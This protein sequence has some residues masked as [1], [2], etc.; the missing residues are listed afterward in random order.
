MDK[1]ALPWYQT[2][3]RW[4]QT[5][6]TEDDPERCDLSFWKQY[7]K[8]TR[9]QG[10]IINAGGIVAYYPSKFPLQYRAATL[11]S[12]DYFGLWNAAAREAGLHVLARMDINRADKNFYQANPDWFC[13]NKDGTPI[14]SQGRYFSC[15]NS[16][17]Y[18]EYIPNVIREISER[19]HPD[20][21]CDNSWKGMGR[22]KICYCQ[23]CRNK[24]RL[25]TGLE[26]PETAS[27]SDP[28][29]PAWIRWSYGCR[30]HIW[31]LL[32]QVTKE[33]GGDH[34][35]YLGMINADP[36]NAKGSFVDLKAICSRS[37]IILS[38]H[39]SRDSISGFEQNSVNGNLLRLASEEQ[40]NVPESMAHY[41]RGPHT[42]RLAANPAEETQTWIAS[43]IAG[44]I[45]PWYHHVGGSQNDRRQF[46][47]SLPLFQWH[48]ENETYL[49]NRTNLANVGVVWSQENTDFFGREDAQE[50]VAYPWF[51][52]CR[53]LSKTRIPFL[54][55]HAADIAR[56]SER[57]QTLILPCI[58][59]LSSEQELAVLDFLRKGGNVVLTGECGTRDP[60]GNLKGTSALMNYLGLRNT[61]QIKGVFG[62]HK[63]DWE[64]FSA[65][66]YLRLPKERHPIFQTFEHTE[67]IGFGGGV[68]VTESYGNLRP[69]SS[70]VAPF[71]VYPPEFSW[72]RTDLS[73]IGTIFAGELP[74]GGRAVYFA[75]D[76]DRCYGRFMLPDHAKLIG[77]AVKWAANGMLPLNVEGPGALDCCIYQQGKRYIVHLVNLSGCRDSYGYRDEV[78]PVGPLT[79]SVYTNHDN[80]K[81]ARLTVA[82][83]EAPVENCNGTA[84]C[85]IHQVGLHEMLVF[86]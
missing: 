46:D 7:W 82:G 14:I 72:I 85:K 2:V 6:L 18:S 41:V 69:V 12:R 48:A 42:F 19:Y 38:D 84:T 66:S 57:L 24:F 50:R 59:I 77:N 27:W 8:Q 13:V 4:G 56:Y 35:L 58:A 11:G 53:A 5:N 63:T 79:I 25:D 37:V 62:T 43:G 30:T 39:Q 40:V 15:V 16:G 49:Y 75:A 67:I 17:Y 34:C 33:L 26:L 54:P 61:G 36:T 20:G 73:D 28:N 22:N 86:E 52:I 31:D 80:I 78:Y 71:P 1:N 76:L 65:H 10:I 60:D 29:Y 55:I 9:I 68:L 70:F 44:G 21:F 83:V 3:H 64:H 51:G 47:T 32:N 81:T 45:S 74:S 23:N